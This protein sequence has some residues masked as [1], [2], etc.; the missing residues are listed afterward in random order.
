MSF[1]FAL[2]IVPVNLQIR[3]AELEKVSCP[4]D[5]VYKDAITRRSPPIAVSV[6]S[7]IEAVAAKFIVKSLILEASV[8]AK[9][10]ASNAK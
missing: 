1:T 6:R 10:L 9:P 4:I 2:S 7:I 3:D 8:D 5:W